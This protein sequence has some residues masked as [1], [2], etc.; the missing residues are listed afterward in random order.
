MV[1]AHEFAHV[2]QFSHRF[3]RTGPLMALYMSE[4]QA[5]LAEKIVGYSILVNDVGQNL[6]V[7]V[8]FNFDETQS[9]PWYFNPWIDLAYYFG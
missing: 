1:I 6:G 5:T 4:G 8:A 9:F 7:A 2:I 3:T